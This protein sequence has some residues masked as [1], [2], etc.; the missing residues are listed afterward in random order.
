MKC[1]WGLMLPTAIC[2]GFL[3]TAVSNAASWLKTGSSTSRP[4]GHIDYCSR[5]PS[6]CTARSKAAKPA[7]VSLSTL[8]S[9]NTS[10]NRAIKPVTDQKQLGIREK[11]SV[12]VKAG[13]CEDFALAKR[14]ALMR[15]G[16]AKSN[17][18]LAVGRANGEAHTVLVVRTTSGD[19]VMDNLTD[20][21]MPAAGSRLGIRKIQSPVHGA[22]WLSVTGSTN[23]PS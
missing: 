12:S 18:L 9:V 19:F 14:S 6:D 22:D 7:A 2:A 10:V 13:D 11:W 4:F 16:V 23:S 8:Q 3:G 17:L 20:T 5:H 15:K 21:V 1:R